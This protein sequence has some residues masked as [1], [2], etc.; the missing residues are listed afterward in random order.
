MHTLPRALRDLPIRFRAISIAQDPTASAGIPI[1][2]TT[3]PGCGSFDDATSNIGRNNEYD[4]V[5][6]DGDGSSL[7]VPAY[8]DYTRDVA[9]RV[10][11]A[12]H[13]M[14]GQWRGAPF[15]PFS[16]IFLAGTSTYVYR[17]DGRLASVNDRDE[18]HAFTYDAR[19]QLATQTV[20][21]GVYAYAYDELGRSTR[22]DFP[23]GHQRVQIFDD[24]GRITSRCYHYPSDGSLDRCYSAS[25]DAVGNPVSL[26]DPE[27]TDVLTYDALDRLTS[28]TRNGVLTE[29]YAYNALGALTDNG[30]VAMDH[31]RPRL[32]GTGLAD[33]AVPATLAG[34]PVT[35]DGGGRITSVRDVGF[36][37]GRF[38]KLEQI[39]EPG[40]VPPRYWGFDATGNLAWKLKGSTVVGSELYLYEGG[41]R[42]AQVIHDDSRGYVTGEQFLY[43]GI[44]HP[45]RGRNYA[46]GPPVG[47]TLPGPVTADFSYELD[48]AGN[49]RRLRAPGGADLGGYRFS[50]FGK[51]LENTAT[52]EQPLRWKGR[53]LD[54]YA[55]LELYDMRA[56]QWVPEL[57]TFLAID[58][59]AFHDAKGTLWPTDGPA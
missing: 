40:P 15:D 23:D 49:V 31:Q 32:D 29:T 28:V 59:F 10:T 43:A 20:R 58:E 42:I 2:K 3:L 27:G 50:A 17:P 41:N 14:S 26:S 56:R 25:Y 18:L 54:S 21:E 22:I 6:T 44:D 30:G 36:R 4:V 13:N 16:G 53:W 8:D 11:F 34:S 12:S 57:G 47:S 46:Y 33:A 35:L 19:G 7:R 51:T 24:L 5:H 9:G 38:G 45:L 48:L 1:R 55:G 37:F 39:T 52:V